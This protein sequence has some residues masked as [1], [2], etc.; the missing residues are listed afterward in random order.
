MMSS[1]GG[2]SSQGQ[3]R[4]WTN[5]TLRASA[6]ILGV[7]VYSTPCIQLFTKV[8]ESQMWIK[9]F[10][11]NSLILAH[12]KSRGCQNNLVI[13]ETESRGKIYN[14]RYHNWC[15]RN[16][17]HIKSRNQRDLLLFVVQMKPNFTID[18]N[19]PTPPR[20]PFFF[21]FFFLFWLLQKAL[22]NYSP[23]HS[24]KY[25]CIKEHSNKQ[26]SQL[27]IKNDMHTYYL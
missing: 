5:G 11:Q 2:D 15:E 7:M 6:T 12:I 17:E 24:N 26:T 19:P 23:Q 10:D 27:M 1:K 3:T 16:M 13:Y 22:E 9:R 8:L 18:D 14:L 20:V 25:S 4:C 21:F